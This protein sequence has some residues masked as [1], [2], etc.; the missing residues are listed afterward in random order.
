MNLNW[1]KLRIFHAVAEAGSFTRACEVLNLSQSAISRQIGALEEQL[2]APL[3]HRHARGLLMTEQGELLLKATKDV[4]E[5]LALLEGRISD[6]KSAPEGPLKLTMPGFIGS[7]WMGPRIDRFRRKYPKM[8]LTL[9]LDNRVF[10]LSM[11]EADAALRLYEPDQPDLIKR[12][13]ATIR[14][15]LCASKS[16][17]AESGTP[18]TAADLRKHWLVGYPAGVPIP[19][20]HTDWLFQLAGV[21]KETA[22]KVLL[23]NAMQA[24]HNTVAG[25]CG[26]GCLPDFMIGDNP[27]LQI[28]LDQYP[29]PEVPIFFV[30]PQERRN[31]TKIQVL[32]DFLI[33][34]VAHSVL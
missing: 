13:L 14:F 4:F 3:F 1:D 22:P 17:L 16:Y 12:K 30:Y 29:A 27:N 32:R 19:H 18:K 26:I 25:G 15:H 9:L 8:C 23:M 6:T 7:A 10:N 5:K 11:R 2:G 34:E 31:S 28:I 24:I 21:D 33:D 20:E